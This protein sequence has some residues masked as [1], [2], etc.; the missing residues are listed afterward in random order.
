MMAPFDILTLAK[1]DCFIPLKRQSKEPI[2]ASWPSSGRPLESINS[3]SNNVGILLGEPSGVLDIDL[4][5]LEAKELAPIILPKPSACFSWGSPSSGHYFY[6]ANDFGPRTSFSS[7]E[8]GTLLELRGDGSQTMC[9]P[10]VHPSGNM[11][12]FTTLNSEAESVCYQDLKRC[13]SLLAAS[14]EV[15]Q[16]WIEGIR[17]DLAL[18]FAGLCLKEGVDP[19]LIVHIIQGICKI[20]GDAEALDRINAAKNTCAKPPSLV[21]GYEGLVE[22]FGLKTARRLADNVK[23]YCGHETTQSVSVYTPSNVLPL[24]VGSFADRSNLTEARIGQAFNCWLADKA[25]HIQNT[26]RWMVWNGIHYELDERN[27]ILNL[28]HQ[29]ISE[30]KTRLF[31]E[32]KHSDAE[33]VKAFESLRKLENITK[34]ASI[35]R[36]VSQEYLDQEQYLVAAENTWINLKTGEAVDPSPETLITKRLEAPYHKGA[37]CPQFLHFLD[38]IFEGNQELI[39]FVQRA[40]GYSLTGSIEEQ[41]FFIMIG[42]GA[43]WSSPLKVVHQLG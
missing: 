17:H 31:R 15:S 14:A 33:S 41:C 7:D 28:A 37:K 1:L 24:S 20:T 30:I 40:I 5:C 19:N 23:A 11:L 43:N 16:R 8:T 32:G 2:E 26:K 3:K 27:A 12:E 25:I 10:S 42:D 29:F 18:A 9:P 35:D 13:A 4:D 6:K 34:L 36:S 21:R 38:Q 22:L 39:R